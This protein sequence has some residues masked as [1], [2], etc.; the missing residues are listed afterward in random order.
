MA[1][2]DVGPSLT[3]HKW[4]SV[5]QIWPNSSRTRPESSRLSTNFGR[6]KPKQYRPRPIPLV[7]TNQCAAT[8]VQQIFRKDYCATQHAKLAQ[9]TSPQSWATTTDITMRGGAIGSAQEFRNESGNRKTAEL[10]RCTFLVNNGGPVLTI[11]PARSQRVRAPNTPRKCRLC[12]PVHARARARPTRALSCAR[13]RVR[14][15]AP[16]ALAR[17]RRPRRR[18]RPACRP[19]GRGARM[20]VGEARA[21]RFSRGETHPGAS[22]NGA[23]G[24]KAK[25]A[26][27][28]DAGHAGA[29]GRCRR[30]ARGWRRSP[31]TPACRYAIPA[32]RRLRRRWLST[33]R[34]GRRPDDRR[35]MGNSKRRHRPNNRPTPLRTRCPPASASPPPLSRPLPTRV[36]RARVRAPRAPACA[37]TPASRQPMRALMRTCAQRARARRACAPHA[38]ARRPPASACALR[39]KSERTLFT[40]TS[41]DHSIDRLN[42]RP[43][44]RRGL[45]D[46]PPTICGKVR[47]ESDTIWPTTTE[48]G[49]CS[50]IVGRIS[51]SRASVRQLWSNCLA[52]LRSSPGAPKVLIPVR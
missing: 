9:I 41:T 39:I 48:V 17:A 33:A 8:R 50:S 47:P 18:A 34:D 23:H 31:R 16:P 22:P 15:H 3:S 29:G 5:H 51:T 46:A 24:A 7:E 28:H 19:R 4:V 2:V 35:R 10:G 11:R 20:E 13:A 49:Q 26:P 37:S 21:W 45:T 32:A 25:S 42:H 43:T 12:V 1:D 30:A 40:T 52:Q 14:V 27:R 44:Q 6:T 38:R 36:E